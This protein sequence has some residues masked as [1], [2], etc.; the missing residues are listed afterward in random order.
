MKRLIETAAAPSLLL[1]Y[2]GWR[3]SEAEGAQTYW[4]LGPRSEAETSE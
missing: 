1:F 3:I 2:S 4:N